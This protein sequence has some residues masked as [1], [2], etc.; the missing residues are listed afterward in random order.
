MGRVMSE[1]LAIDA[2]NFAYPLDQ[3]LEGCVH[4]ELRKAFAGFTI[5]TAWSFDQI[6]TGNWGCGVFG[7]D[8]HLKSWSF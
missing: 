7:G 1:L 5:H 6:A 3:F 4:R 8:F 2:L